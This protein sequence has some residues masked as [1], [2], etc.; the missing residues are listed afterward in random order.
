MN[1]SREQPTV[2]STTCPFHCVAEITQLFFQGISLFTLNFN[3]PIL[4]TAAAAAFLFQGLGK[5]FQGSRGQGETI[6][7]S[8]AFSFA[9]LCLPHE[10]DNAIL[11]YRLLLS[12][13]ALLCRLAA[14]RAHGSGFG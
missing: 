2:Y 7:Q 14:F 6:D 12:A 4:D 13:D 9:P 11:R 8:D 1:S 3:H 10:S 5:F